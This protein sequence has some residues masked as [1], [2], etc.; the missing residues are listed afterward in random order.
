MLPR[1]Q[2][3]WKHGVWA[4]HRAQA[5]TEGPR[6][7]LLTSSQRSETT[8]TASPPPRSGPASR[9]SSGLV[10]PHPARNQRL[11]DSLKAPP[12]DPSSPAKTKGTLR[13]TPEIHERFRPDCGST[14]NSLRPPPPPDELKASFRRMRPK[15]VSN[16]AAAFLSH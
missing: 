4:Q 2:V 1:W 13:K 5:L 10:K 3:P 7:H 14:P 8:T 12:N 11:P 15:H 9:S 16:K 6:E